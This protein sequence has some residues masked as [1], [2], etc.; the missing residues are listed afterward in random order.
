MRPRHLG[1]GDEVAAAQFDTVDAQIL[2]R[3]VDQPLAEEIALEPAG[4]AIGPDRRLVGGGER[5]LDMDVGDAIGAGDHLRAIAR[6]GRAVGADIGAH[7]GMEPPAHAEDGAVAPAGDLELAIELA[8][9]V[10]GEEMLAPVLDPFD[11]PAEMARREGDEE[12]LGIELAAHAE[13][14]ADI[15]LDHRDGVLGEPHLARE[16]AP[17]G[18]RA[19]WPRPKR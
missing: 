9:M 2:R 4:R 15:V 3:H 1:V 7:V 8:G 6:R 13:A 19:A 16:H 5:R 17:V 12:I 18:E 11:R 10:A 14:A